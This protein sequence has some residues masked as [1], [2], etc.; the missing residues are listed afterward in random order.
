MNLIITDM[1]PRF[2]ADYGHGTPIRTPGAYRIATILDC[3]VV[4]YFFHV[5]YDSQVKI[6]NKLKMR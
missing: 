5:S 3:P 4:D 1:T 6:L 2:N